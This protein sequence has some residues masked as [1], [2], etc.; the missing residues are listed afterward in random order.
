MNWSLSI[1]FIGRLLYTEACVLL[2]I[3]ALRGPPSSFIGSVVEWIGFMLEVESFLGR[4]KP[5]TFGAGRRL[6]SSVSNMD[7]FL[8]AKM[9]FRY[10]ANNK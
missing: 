9:S 10:P 6:C 1:F 2:S 7:C 4:L 3:L 8:C 5:P